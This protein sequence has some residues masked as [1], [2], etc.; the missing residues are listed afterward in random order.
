MGDSGWTSPAARD[1][2][3]DLRATRGDP[4]AGAAEVGP[5]TGSGRHPEERFREQG[6]AAIQW[7][8]GWPFIHFRVWVPIQQINES[9]KKS[10]DWNS[11]GVTGDG[12][13][14]E[15]TGDKI[16]TGD[17]TSDKIVT[18]EAFSPVKLT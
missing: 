4:G 15:V 12:G 8:A 17:I 2:G 16:F 1:G 9:I 13:Y 10:R 3:G 6:G 18:G 11:D 7:L 14:G 5:A